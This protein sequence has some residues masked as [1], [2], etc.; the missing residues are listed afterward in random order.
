MPA[1]FKMYINPNIKMID[2]HILVLDNN[3]MS[4]AL[5]FHKRVMLNSVAADSREAGGGCPGKPE[6]TDLE[7][8]GIGDQSGVS[9]LAN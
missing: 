5:I 1:K 9:S 6:P 7:P 2:A 4:T 8:A 3:N